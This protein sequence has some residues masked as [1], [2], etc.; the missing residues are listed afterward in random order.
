MLIIPEVRA[1][2]FP[3]K[4]PPAPI[5]DQTEQKTLREI[6]FQTPVFNSYV[7]LELFLF[8]LHFL[9][10]PWHSIFNSPTAVLA[11]CLEQAPHCPRAPR[12]GYLKKTIIT[13]YQD[14][15]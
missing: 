8:T 5:I 7:H 10:L 6:S 9:L 3:S 4:D 12:A 1:F 2:I 13:E 11:A 15:H 14:I